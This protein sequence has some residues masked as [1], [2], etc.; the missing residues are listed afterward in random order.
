MRDYQIVALI[1]IGVALVSLAWYA[2][3]SLDT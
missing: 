3:K 1:M 2:L